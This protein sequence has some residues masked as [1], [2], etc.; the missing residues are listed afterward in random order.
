MGLEMYF[1]KSF[2]SRVRLAAFKF[3]EDNTRLQGELFSRPTL[4]EGFK[5]NNTRIPLISPRGIF[6]PKVLKFPLSITTIPPSEK[7]PKPYDDS[8]NGEILEYRYQGTDPNHPDNVGL[9]KAMERQLPLIYFFGLVPNKYLPCWPVYVVGDDTRN[10]T[11]K[12]L[13]DDPKMM[14]VEEEDFCVAE[15]DSEARRQYIT[16]SLK[17]RLHQKSFRERVL[18]AYK[19]QCSICQLRHT[20]LLEAA[21]ILPD[22]HP[23]GEP[24]VS[25]GL[26]L[27]KLHHA[28]YDRNIL[29]ITPGLQVQIRQDILEEIDGPMLLHGLQGF[30]GAKISTPKSSQLKPNPAFLEERFQIF[31]AAY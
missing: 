3:L 17:I 16:S 24:V 27:C 23:L 18:N 9:R 8:F 20:E 1:D 15:D 6:K 26:A 21:H 29:G 31:I 2:D 22:K 14:G 10:L 19:D 25:N 11:F 28:A 12:V 30:Q 7:R 4:L 5:F 13:L